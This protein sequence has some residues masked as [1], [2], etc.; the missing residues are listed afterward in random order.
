MFMDCPARTETQEFNI[1]EPFQG[2]VNDTKFTANITKPE[3]LVKV[4]CDVHPW[5]FCYAGVQDNPFFAVTDKD[6]HYTIP[7]VPPGDYTLTAYHLKTHGS[8]PGVTQ[9]ITVAAG[10]TTADFT[11][12]A[13][14]PK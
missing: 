1:A 7:N 6:G 13:P 4:K 11:V 10:P 5:M 3:V 14:A 12:D 2:Q 8:A 9:Q